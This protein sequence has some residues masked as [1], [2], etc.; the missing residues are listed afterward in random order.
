[1]RIHHREKGAPFG[2]GNQQTYPYD[3]ERGD[4]TLLIVWSPKRREVETQY[5][6]GGKKTF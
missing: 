1:L 4:S 6:R 3:E 5:I 2:S